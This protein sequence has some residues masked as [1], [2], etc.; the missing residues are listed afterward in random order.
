MEFGICGGIDS[1][2]SIKKSGADY[3]ESTV[4]GA[5]SM[6]EEKRNDF[7]N[8]LLKHKICCAAFNVLFPGDLPLT[9]PEAEPKKI[10]NYLDESFSQISVFSP[11]VVVFGS[12]QARKKPDGYATDKAFD[13]LVGVGRA[14][15]LEAKKHGFA[16]AFEALNSNE[17]NLIN[18]LIEAKKLVQ[19]VNEKNFGMVADIFHMQIENEPPEHINECSQYINHIHVATKKG[20]KFPFQSDE[21]ELKPYFQALFNINYKGLVSIEAQTE[22]LEHDAFVSL[23]LL[24]SW[25]P[26]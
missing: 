18:N 2:Q 8:L 12:G 10:N 21:T 25:L 14:A 9:G 5:C 16:I 24:R 22:N 4:V 17:T 7:H 13:Q 23:K 1:L 15:A 26:Q 6:S 11:S 20:R 3:I 19:A